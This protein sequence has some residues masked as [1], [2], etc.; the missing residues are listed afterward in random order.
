[1]QQ[2]AQKDIKL[3]EKERE[4]VCVTRPKDCEYGANQVM[5][6]EESRKA[7]GVGLIFG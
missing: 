5:E 2:E 4:S 7:R 3:K 6:Y 1:M